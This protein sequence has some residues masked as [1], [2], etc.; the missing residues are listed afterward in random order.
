M[1]ETTL[2]EAVDLRLKIGP[3]QLLHGVSFAVRQGECL[4]IVGET[5]S[6]KS[7]TCRVIAGLG[8]RLAGGEIEGQ[9][10]L[11][12]QD[13]LALSEREWAAKIRGR[14]IGMVPQ[15]S[16]NGL[17]PV[18]RIRRQM[19]ETIGHLDPEADPIPRAKE[20]LEQM[21]MPRADEILELYPHELS[22]GMRQRVMIALALAGG[23]RLLIADEP[24][25]ALDVTVQNGI[26]ELLKELRAEREMSVILVTHDLGVV[27]SI[28]DSVAIM[29]AGRVVEQGATATVL[30]DPGHPYTEA[31]LKARPVL[32][33]NE[34]MLATIPGSPPPG[35]VEIP[36]CPFAPRCSY[37]VERCRREDPPLAAV[38][39]THRAACWRT[40]EVG[41]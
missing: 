33:G 30:G 22:G 26:L 21:H 7:L 3:A 34:E 23:P 20:L 19:T 11:D 5:G 27:E 16:L 13:L 9:V 28:A 2:L 6:G 36:G 32:G 1:S 17:D 35:G 39:G 31:L 18:M 12:D 41:V 10:R 38:G 14:Q 15:A 24:T 40:E 37:V 29:Y 4:G 25:T 8:R